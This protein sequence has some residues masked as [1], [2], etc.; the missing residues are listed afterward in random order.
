[1]WL[2]NTD[3][4]ELEEFANH[5]EH[6]YAILSHRWEETEVSFRSW[7][8]RESI[9]TQGCRKIT[10]FVQKAAEGGFKYAWADTCCI[11][12]ES[13]AEQSEAINSMFKYY[14]DSAECYVYLSDLPP[15]SRSDNGGLVHK[16]S[17]T[18][19]SIEESRDRAFLNSKWFTRGWTLQELIAPDTVLFF[20]SDWLSF[21][22]KKSLKDRIED[23]TGIPQSILNGSKR[24]QSCPVACRMSWAANRQTTRTEDMAYCLLGIFNIH[25]PLLYGEGQVA[26]TRLQEEICR[27]TTDMSLFAWKSIQP[28]DLYSGLLARSPSNFR[29]S[30]KVNSWS[31]AHQTDFN[32]EI[33]VTNKGIRFDNMPLFFSNQYGVLLDLNCTDKTNEGT[34]AKLFICL[35]R[36]SERWVRCRAP[37]IVYLDAYARTGLSTLQIS[38]IFI[39]ATMEPGSIRSSHL[40]SHT[41]LFE[42]S[43]GITLISAEPS[44]LWEPG[45][46]GFLWNPGL[47]G[48][49]H[50]STR[51]EH[52]E[53]EE[54]IIL[55][56]ISYP[57][58]TNIGAWFKPYWFI[59]L[60]QQH[61]YFE[62]TRDLVRRQ[63]L[64]TRDGYQTIR[65]YVERNTSK[66]CWNEKESCYIENRAIGVGHK[67]SVRAQV[68]SKQGADGD[69]W[70]V[71]KL[72]ILSSKR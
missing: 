11:N 65:H 63:K 40:F 5:T 54:F 35:S 3:T 38:R 14:Q 18:F 60:G 69:S 24:V 37:E 20:D 10:R 32:D 50:I 8:A 21:G 36:T 61:A 67:I 42:F 68:I 59:A 58:S 30:A 12:K 44:H 1:M 23:R 45:M 26:F 15:L 46:Q 27:K 17:E 64:H 53:S 6:E 25:M 72:H 57:N 2:I 13:S 55:C 66:S 48:A 39:R 31:S 56:G 4:L 28:D 41:M 16:S 34:F 52:R 70:D 7:A 9:Q 33:A 43:P 51:L 47:C 29:D 22:T 19:I 49:V 62:K 71:I